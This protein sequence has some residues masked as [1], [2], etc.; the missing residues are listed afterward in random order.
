MRAAMTEKCAAEPALVAAEGQNK[1]VPVASALSLRQQ[2]EVQGQVQAQKSQQEIP[3]MRQ[4]N[5]CPKLLE[6]V[7]LTMKLAMSKMTQMSVFLKCAVGSSKQQN[8]GKT[9]QKQE[10][11]M[12]MKNVR[13]AAWNQSHLTLPESLAESRSFVV[14]QTSHQTLLR[15]T[16]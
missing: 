12:Q 6:P 7:Q 8:L 16:K 1:T 14:D 2:Q 4:A 15:A 5:S 10:T 13:T 3:E 11:A 9:Q